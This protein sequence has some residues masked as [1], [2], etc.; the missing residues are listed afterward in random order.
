MHRAYAVLD[1][2][3]HLQYVE[4]PKGTSYSDGT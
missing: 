2:L 3:E 4:P 1:A